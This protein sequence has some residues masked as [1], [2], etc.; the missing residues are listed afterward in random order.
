ME[1]N[2]NVKKERKMGCYPWKLPFK[3]KKIQ[4]RI[5][6]SINILFFFI[7]FLLILLIE[8]NVS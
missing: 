1:D 3:S 5:Q 7:F 2:K 8:K 6:R 4:V